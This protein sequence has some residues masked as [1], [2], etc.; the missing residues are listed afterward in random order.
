MLG[1]HNSWVLLYT[2]GVIRV[3]ITLPIRQIL[4]VETITGDKLTQGDRDHD[5]Q[6]A[7]SFAN[8]ITDDSS[9]EW[10]E[11]VRYRDQTNKSVVLGTR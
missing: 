10:D 1:I 3:F 11:Y 7:F 2:A 9:E 6:E 5:N 8:P 4:D